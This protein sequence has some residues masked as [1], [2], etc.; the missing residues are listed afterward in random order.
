MGMGRG[1]SGL[2]ESALKG[3][4]GCLGRCTGMPFIKRSIREFVDVF[5]WLTAAAEIILSVIDLIR[6]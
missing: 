1:G 4:W 3:G 5:L 2:A 6:G